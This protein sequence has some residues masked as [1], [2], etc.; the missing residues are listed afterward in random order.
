MMFRKPK[1]Q[2]SYPR[3]V[4]FFYFAYLFDILLAMALGSLSVTTMMAINETKSYWP[5]FLWVG[6]AGVFFAGLIVF[7]SLAIHQD[8]DRK[9][10][11]PYVSLLSFIALFAEVGA[12]ALY[13]YLA[14]FIIDSMTYF[15]IELAFALLV[16]FVPLLFIVVARKG[17]ANESTAI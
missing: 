6:F 15:Y 11:M 4:F 12:A 9:R 1:K 5:F 16:F 13:A 8:F 17:K 10:I 14:K 7:L 3:F 2:P